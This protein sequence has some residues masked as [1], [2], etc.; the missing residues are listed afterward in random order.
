MAKK[1]KSPQEKKE[2]S[3]KRD[4]RNTYGEND[5]SSRKNIPRS[6][7]ISL[8]AVRRTAKTD[9]RRVA[10]D[11]DTRAEI[12][13]STLTKRRLQKGDWKKG[14]DEPLGKVIKD[15]LKAR[16]RREGRKSAARKGR[17]ATRA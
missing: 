14:P 6:K 8:R 9:T 11:N 7:A 4:R 1:Q 12:T 13:A 16:V 5:K 15:Q 3:L 10:D 17:D 2:L